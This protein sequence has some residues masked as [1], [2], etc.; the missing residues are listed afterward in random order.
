MNCELICSLSIYQNSS[1]VEEYFIL[2]SSVTFETFKKFVVDNFTKTSEILIKNNSGKVISSTKE[3]KELFTDS[4]KYI[5]QV[6]ICVDIVNTRKEKIHKELL[7][8]TKERENWTF[9]EPKISSFVVCENQNSNP[10]AKLFKELHKAVKDKKNQKFEEPN[11]KKTFPIVIDC[12]LMF[13]E[14]LYKSNNQRTFKEPKI[15]KNFPVVRDNSKMFNELY[16]TVARRDKNFVEPKISKNFPIIENHRISREALFNEMF[17]KIAEDSYKEFKEPKISNSFPIVR[18]NLPVK[19][20]GT[21]VFNEMF[22]KIAE[23]SYKEFKEPKISA[24]PIVRV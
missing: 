13:D 8:V 10:R 23:N 2:D 14:L 20:L 24:F 17:K 22:K 16:K 1:K 12:N 6:S 5:N 11:V 3:L 19:R 4:T 15:S 18:E 21:N 9:V 7:Q